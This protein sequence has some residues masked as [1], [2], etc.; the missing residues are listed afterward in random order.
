MKSAV[1]D[2][3]STARNT[4]L[5]VEHTST[6]CANTISANV[7]NFIVHPEKAP[8]DY[9]TSIYLNMRATT[10]PYH[11]SSDFATGNQKEFRCQGTS[12]LS[13][14]NA[15]LRSRLPVNVPSAL[16]PCASLDGTVNSAT[17][18]MHRAPVNLR[19]ERGMRDRP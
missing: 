13:S 5:V 17:I 18:H 15:R 19:T 3:I 10:M 12:S 9:V 14:I 4:V 6:H 7:W 8:N 11:G 16:V 2:D 1:R